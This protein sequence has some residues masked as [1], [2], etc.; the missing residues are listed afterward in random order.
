MRPA[1]SFDFGQTLCVLDSAMLAGRL[2]ERGVDL[3]A[4]QFRAALPE[5]FAR[6]ER[7]IAAGQGGHPWQVFMHALLELGGVPD[8][9]RAELVPWLWAQQPVKNLWREPIPGMIELVRTLRATGTRVGILSNSEGKLAELVAELD[10]T[11]DFDAIADSGVL[12]MEKP[13]RPIFAWT[14][15]RLGVP[16]ERLIHVGDLVAADVVGALNAGAQAIWFGPAA[17]E[18]KVPAGAHVARDAR[19]LR[20]VL[21]RLGV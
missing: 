9:L 18:A 10:W 4:S 21:T 2:R 1:V 17:S 12:G 3:P 11:D 15:E 13:D 20:A 14:A 7:A 19:E 16:L 8:G 5:A 6:Y